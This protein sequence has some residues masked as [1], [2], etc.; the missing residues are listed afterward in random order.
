MTAEVATVKGADTVQN[1]EKTF[2]A[3]VEEWLADIANADEKQNNGRRARSPKT[4]TSY[5][6]A[7]G[8]FKKWL[9]DSG[10]VT[11]AEQ[12]LKNWRGAL[13]KKV[14]AEVLSIKTANLLV[15]SVRSLFKW[16]SDNHGLRNLAAGIEGWKVSSEHKRGFLNLPEMKRLMSIVDTADLS[17]N[18]KKI[19]KRDE[20]MIKL[21]RLRDK[22]ILA[23]MAGGGL[24]TV[25]VVRLKVRDLHRDAGTAFLKVLGKG[26]TDT[27]DVK[28]SA[29]IENAIQAWSDARESVDIVTDDSPLFCSLGN[30]SFGG[31][32][33]TH[34]ISVTTKKYLELA[35]LKVKVEK[36]GDKKVVKP[37]T[38]HS[39]RA[40]LATESYLNGATLDQVKQQLRHENVATT[41][42]YIREA[43]KRLN[44]C[45]DIVSSYIF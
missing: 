33:T 45:T 14:K 36:N 3:I 16:L 2:W 12:D 27:V 35:G 9:D 13:D 42:I 5:R 31:Q 29:K 26:K 40:S 25:E 18:R 7:L 39:L 6:Y 38:A 44:P 15:A 41:L 10:V 20:Q 8:V 32:L 11:P 17:G 30:N 28:I 24:R 22:A 21:R 37:V 34:T 4:I 1:A 19:S 23:V 43:E